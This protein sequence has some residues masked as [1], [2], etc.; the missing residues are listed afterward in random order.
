MSIFYFTIC[1]CNFCFSGFLLWR[2][3]AFQLAFEA[4]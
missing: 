3:H 4:F 1:S 2:L